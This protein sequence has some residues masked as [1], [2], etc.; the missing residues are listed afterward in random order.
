MGKYIVFIVYI[1][2]ELRMYAQI[3]IVRLIYLLKHIIN[4]HCQFYLPTLGKLF[5]NVYFQTENTITYIIISVYCIHYACL[6]IIL[7]TCGMALLL[8]T[9]IV[10]VE[11]AFLISVY[12]VEPAECLGSEPRRWF[13]L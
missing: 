5:L 12:I 4:Q 8:W 10:Y 9:C 2:D 6:L 3:I 13:P 11:C 7:C 1:N